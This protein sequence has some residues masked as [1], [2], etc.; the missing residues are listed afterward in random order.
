LL[1][2][3]GA[4]S[5]QFNSASYLVAENAGAVTITVTRLGNVSLAASVD[6]V[7]S[8]G[9]ASAKTDYTPVSKTLQFAGGETF[10]AFT[11]PVVDNSY[12]QGS[13]TVNV[14][15]TNATA[16]AFPG[17]PTTAT[18]TIFDNDTAA[19]TGNPLDVAQ[20]FVNQHYLDFLGRIPDVAGFDYWSNKITTCGPDT[21]CVN[22]ERIG[23]SA[24]FFI[25]QEFQQT[26]SFVYRLYKGSLGRRP[27]YAEFVLDR[28]K[29]V[30]GSDLAASKVALLNDFVLRAEFKQTYPDALSNSQFVNLLFDTAGLVPFT[31][32]RQQQIDAMNLGKT[33]AQV[34]GD[35]IEIQVFKDR[36][37]NPSFVL[38]QYFG[39]LRRNP[40]AGG[41]AFWLDIITNQDPNNYRGMVCSFITSAEY[42]QRFSSVV[43]HSN[44]ECAGVH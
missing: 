31:A 39:Y 7:T 43:T 42:Q 4:S 17:S 30:G 25:E 22:A 26:G 16:G 18:V 13:R 32:E 3:A 35:V 14:S 44:A 9:T 12:V 27:T 34:V 10:K 5:F 33:R 38:M 37:Y 8:G 19:P 40:D 28:G 23:V 21:A 24:A 20:F 15:L 1:T 6:V 29:V 41:Y 11:L 36:E 2:S